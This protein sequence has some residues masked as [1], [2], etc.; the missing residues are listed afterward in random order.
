[1]SIARI[2]LNGISDISH[3]ALPSISG[4]SVYQGRGSFRRKPGYLEL[5]L[6][7]EIFTLFNQA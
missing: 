5:R 6:S 7:K 4:R 3:P 1:M 2:R